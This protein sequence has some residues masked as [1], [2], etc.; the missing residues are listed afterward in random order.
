MTTTATPTDQQRRGSLGGALAQEWMRL[1]TLRSTWWLTA[2][3]IAIS[4][5]IA[6]GLVFDAGSSTAG[7]SGDFSGGGA[8]GDRQSPAAVLGDQESFA[9]VLSSAGLLV[10]LLMGLL[11]AFA[12]GHEY[13][14]G[15]ILSALT[16]TPRR[17]S[18][19]VAKVV[20]LAAY[21]GFVGV[22]C[23]A[24]SALV[25]TLFSSRFAPGVSLTGGAT[26]RVAGG[27][28]LYIVLVA[29]LGLGLGWLLRS[30][31]AAV[32]IMLVFPLIGETLIRLLLSID[33]LEPI[34]G[35]GRY[36]PFSAG[37]QLL[38]Y[39]TAID[40]NV[41]EAFFNDLTPL[42]GGLTLAAVVAV[43]LGAAYLLFQRRDA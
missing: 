29:L 43:V 23:V 16:G 6:V 15:T 5:A 11:G 20:V 10:P 41:P 27:T 7:R 18:V 36:L 19:A 28:V 42:V 24:L 40:P 21:A 33:F 35:I 4:L 25:A 14:Y 30:I 12:F 32:S 31:P 3:A 26:E 2:G 22:V 13:R 9:A 1:R 37:A 39:S 17:S 8:P 34:Q 38:D